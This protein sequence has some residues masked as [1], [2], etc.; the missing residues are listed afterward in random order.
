MARGAARGAA[1]AGVSA[2]W[3]LAW[4]W[5]LAALPLPWLVR[6]VLP[7]EPLERDAAL[8]V[9]VAAEFAELVGGRS[10]LAARRRLAVLSA[11]WVLT[12]VAAARPQFVG[13]PVAL[14]MTG[15]DLLLSV[16][17]SGSMEEQDFQLNGEWVD[18]LTAL[19][20][21]ATDFIE[22]RVGDRIGLILF[23][24]EAYLQV[25]LTFDRKTVSALLSEVVIGLAGKETAI[26]DSIGL[27]I[28]TL[29]DAGV[30]EGR[31]V[32][33]LL[34]DGAN[35]AGAV[36]PRKAAELAAQRKV[37]IYTIGIGADSLT[38]R[39][40]FGLREINPS[41]DL[42]EEALTAIAQ[43]TGGRYFRARDTAEFAKIYDIL[44]ELEPAESDERGF[45]PVTEL[46][47][48]PLSAAVVLALAAA[49]AALAASRW[50][51]A[52][53]PVRRL[54]GAAHG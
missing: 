16:D 32:V 27:A 48:W 5:M 35:T 41:A 39:S 10:P 28:R 43:M 30:E 34:T 53:L 6:R 7:A 11:V 18:R 21:V 12:V 50:R 2:M 33:L 22:R 14:P 24:R 3:T 36:D 52:G 42:D 9:P 26:G 54:R 4:W 47:Y 8:K 45:R 49:L 23:G 44:D 13:E 31:R 17:L 20:A 40:L 38:V 51:W 25:P 19:K 46:F 37:V 29:E 1:E 15:R